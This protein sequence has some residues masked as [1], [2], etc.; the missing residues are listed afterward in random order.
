M[1][2]DN[3]ASLCGLCCTPFGS[4]ILMCPKGHSFRA[5]CLAKWMEKE[6]TCPNCRVALPLIDELPRN[7]AL[8]RLVGPSPIPVDR[9]GPPQAITEDLIES[10]PAE[11]VKQE[12]MP[13]FPGYLDAAKAQLQAFLGLMVLPSLNRSSVTNKNGG[14]GSR[15]MVALLFMTACTTNGDAISQ[16]TG[17]FTPRTVSFADIA[18]AGGQ[19]PAGKLLRAELSTTGMV[20]MSNIP[21]FADIKKEVLKLSH[22]CSHDAPSELA[23]ADHKTFADGTVRHSL[24]AGLED[25]SD[26]LAEHSPACKAF[27]V[28]SKRFRQL[29]A[30]ATLSFAE[31][32]DQV[33][34]GAAR[35]LLRSADKQRR[36]DSVGEIVRH[37]DHLEHFHTYSAGS[38]TAKT[39]SSR[40]TIDY[41]TDQ[42]LF[43][44][45]TPAMHLSPSGVL[46]PAR[47]GDFQIEFASGESATVMFHKGHEIVF[48]MGDGINH[49]LNDKLLPGAV[50]PRATPHAFS[51]D[52]G[53]L[54]EPFMGQQSRVWYGK[55]VLPPSEALHSVH[56]VS[57]GKLR[58]MAR[59]VDHKQYGVNPEGDSAFGL[60]C[61]R[62]VM[63][64][65]DQHGRQLGA[66]DCN[67]SSQIFCWMRC[68]DF[69]ATASPDVCAANN[70]AFN[71]TSQFDQ[72]WLPGDGH[73]DY[74]PACSN[75]SSLITASPT[76]APA[77]SSCD[78]DL[79][80]ATTFSAAAVAADLGAALLAE[81]DGWMVLSNTVVLL[82]KDHGDG[83][84]SFKMIK[85]GTTVYLA[86]G[87]PNAG[88]GH[89]GMNGAHIVLASLISGKTPSTDQ[90]IIDQY[91]S[92]WRHWSTPTP[93][94]TALSN[95]SAEKTD[96]RAMM[97]FKA[98][99]ISGWSL[100]ASNTK[101]IKMLWAAHETTNLIG[102]HGHANRGLPTVNLSCTGTAV[103]GTVP[104][105]GGHDNH[106]GHGDGA[107]DD[108][109]DHAHDN[110]AASITVGRVVVGGLA[111]AM[112]N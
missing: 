71:C 9:A 90:Y 60:G 65:L 25:F 89:N 98:S 38:Q 19:S 83:D 21:D 42:G 86:L 110:A 43:I 1:N 58:E 78:N 4:R 79:V 69:T 48:M 61:S 52:L 64:T 87:L 26:Q 82:Y 14:W 62:D 50:K 44:A 108:L 8:E 10:P 105:G 51:S 102:Y 23:Q 7:Y 68:M 57:F 100:N 95:A 104:M 32:L 84:V 59:D 2:D 56:G 81:Y 3:D 31:H 85:Y 46:E 94:V 15:V 70:T 11:P 27:T 66:S 49:I 76:L 103:C 33:F 16:D 22:Q 96:C 72:V 88:G 112:F 55:M 93:N 20:G 41:H 63:H 74:N 36:F 45:F 37:G 30:E 75:T 28:A 24:G 53:T 73:G 39:A 6:A 92:A 29:V 67:A 97:S 99:D 111:L 13:S 101:Q 77:P 17:I 47:N 5:G 107:H 54:S 106:A 40:S 80:D 109:D 91:A 34:S 12:A 18:A 35:P